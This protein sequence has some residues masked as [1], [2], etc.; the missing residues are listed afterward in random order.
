MTL[1][2][3]HAVDVQL[4]DDENTMY[5]GHNSSSVAKLKVY[6][7]TCMD[8]QKI[9]SDGT[10]P[11]LKVSFNG[12]MMMIIQQYDKYEIMSVLS[13][14]LVCSFSGNMMMILQ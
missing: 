11:I 1:T 4:L 9:E 14:S 2:T 7:R 3:T 12:D 6:F 13:S 8:V 5:K 10:G